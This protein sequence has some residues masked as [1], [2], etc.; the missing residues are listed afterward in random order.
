MARMFSNYK[1][2][3]TVIIASIWLGLLTVLW[4]YFFFVA[5]PTQL[6]QVRR[7][8]ST[9]SSPEEDEETGLAT[10]QKYHRLLLNAGQ[11]AIAKILQSSPRRHSLD[12]VIFLSNLLPPI[13]NVTRMTTPSSD[14][15]LQYIAPVGLPVIFTDM[16]TDTKLNNWSWDMIKQR[17][18][19]HIFHNTRQ[20]NY[21]TKVNKAGKHHINR[22]SVKLSRFVDLVTG[23]VEPDEQEKGLYITKQKILPPDAL[24]EEFYYPPFYPGNHHRCYLEPTGW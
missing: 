11:E 18:G 6:Q 7:H 5:K 23:T 20:G 12:H 15:F 21:S 24:D 10:S 17:W 2:S 4:L 1:S 16:L 19:H 3:L 14:T 9:G 13:I 8:V 22:V